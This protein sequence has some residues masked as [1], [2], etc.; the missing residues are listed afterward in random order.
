[1]VNQVHKVGVKIAFSTDAGVSRHGDNAREFPLWIE[2]GMAQMQS[3]VAATINAAE[4]LGPSREI[5]SIGRIKNVV[6]AEA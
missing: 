2:V 4:L 1:M 3:I 5:G 6:A